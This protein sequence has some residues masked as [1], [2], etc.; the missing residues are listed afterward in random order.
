MLKNRLFVYGLFWHDT[1]LLGISALHKTQQCL[2]FTFWPIP[3]DRQSGALTVEPPV[4]PL[5]SV[6]LLPSTV[7]VS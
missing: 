6:Q 1:V 7:A 2:P 4:P 3:F 5:Y